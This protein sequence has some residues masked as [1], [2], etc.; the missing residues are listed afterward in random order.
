[1]GKICDYIIEK[2]NKKILMISS[3][4]FIFFMIVVLPKVSVY[5]EEVTG[6]SNSPDTS[7]IYNSDDLFKIASDYGEEGRDA[8]ILLRFTF[9]LVWPI[10]YFMFLASLIGVMI[11]RLQLKEKYRYLIL[12]PVFGLVF[13]YLE[14]IT[15]V[16]VMYK[17]P[18]EMLFFAN[19]APYMTFLKWIFIGVSFISVLVLLIMSLIKMNS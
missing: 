11:K 6:S 13:D 10:V 18:T 19:V 2:S 8:Y 14:N 3:I 9:D 4:V 5:T 7:L 17:Y 12:L 16:I 15:S 1:M